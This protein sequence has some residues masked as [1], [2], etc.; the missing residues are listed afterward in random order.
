MSVDLSSGLT[1]ALNRALA[2]AREQLDAG[3]HPGAA[4][5]YRSAA[6]LARRLS[7]TST[8]RDAK[9]ERAGMARRYD[10][11][12]AG[13][14]TGRAPV[15]RS[16]VAAEGGASAEAQ[17]YEMFVRSLVFASGVR[18]EDIGG[19]DETKR[20]IKMAYGISLAK[21][22]EGIKSRG[23]RNVLL[24]GPPGTGKTLLAAAT[25]TELDATFFNVKVSNLLSKYF[26]ES[27]KLTTL[28]YEFARSQS[29]SVVFLDE[30]DALTAER[31][32]GD[33]GAERRMLGTVL[34][35]LDG[36]AEKQSDAYVLTIAATNVPWLMDPAA[37]SRFERKVYVPLPEAEARAAIFSI[38]TE[39]AGYKLAVG[40]DMLADMSDAYS[41]REIEQICRDVV[42]TML[43]DCN[44]D[45]TDRV[46]EG[47]EAV[48]QYEL[49]VRPLAYADF[50]R[51]MQGARPATTREQL[52]RYEQWRD[53]L[54]R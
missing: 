3:D 1:A 54:E 33:S 23:W 19:L 47:A 32:A 13:L 7:R 28:L 16:T 25:S 31:G 4:A 10:A 15:S 26:G 27:S 36:L 38:H 17:D 48:R 14:E 51:A 22:P 18:W 8:S 12:A 50:E 52:R 53:G 9:R 6:D 29:P 11:I 34:A 20:D 24:Y 2:Q 41:G 45:L 44:P 5:S 30:F 21:K 40:L 43:T 39:T 46:D 35:E 42:S 37:L 49:K